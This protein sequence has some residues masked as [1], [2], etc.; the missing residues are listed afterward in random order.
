MLE[1]IKGFKELEFDFERPE[2]RFAGWTVF[3]G[4][5]ASGKS[6]LLKS[7]ALAITGPD[8]SRLLLGNPSA[9]GGW[10]HKNER[11]A[12]AKA[13]LTW[14]A[15]VDRFRKGGANPGRLFEAGMR[16]AL[17]GKEGADGEP[18]DEIPTLRAI[19]RRSAVGTRILTADRGPWGPTSV[20]WFSA[21]YG[22]MRRLTGSSSE[23]V[24][25]SLDRSAVGRYVTLFRE[26]AA[27]S[28]SETWLKTNHSR[29]LEDP[30]SE[31]KELLDGVGELL[32]D[33]LLPQGMKISKTTVD[34][35]YVRDGRQLELP[36]RDISDG[37]RGVYATV[38]D[39]VHGMFAV[40]G[41]KG[42]FGKDARGKPVVTRPGVVLIDEIEA[43]LH[44]SWQ[45]D[46]PEWFKQHFPQVQFFVTTHSPLVA[47][48]ADSN[49]VFLLPSPMDVNMQPRALSEDEIN[50]L[51][52]GRA[53]KTLLGVAFGL[54]TV[55]SRWA[56]GQ[57]EKWKRLN[58]KAKS[59]AI[60][61]GAEQQ[62]LAGLK[63]QM[64]IAF[65]PAPEG[66]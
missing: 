41:I 46:I 44:P 66:N 64:E 4:G 55:R 58:S 33:D 8:A 49:G 15:A 17:E 57:I 37:C 12:E 22:P 23:S 53:E 39:L 50:R 1:A 48:A 18:R 38:L 11:R 25:F 54:K 52:L 10:I 29:W 56:N 6:T 7:I 42:L 47:Q 16:F 61:T 45:R 34:H 13:T 19:E 43:H 65:D 26:D 51:R 14:D 35:V 36:M 21:G 32:S 2:G 9:W 28:E 59:G 40:Y 62:E 3:L 30:K 60:L 31:L 63:E 5:N 24:R 27:L 20:G